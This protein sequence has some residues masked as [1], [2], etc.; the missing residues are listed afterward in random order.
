MYI[1]IVAHRKPA[2]IPIMVMLGK[3]S[4]KRF[5]LIYADFLCEY[6]VKFFPIKV[7]VYLYVS[8][9]QDSQRYQ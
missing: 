1:I 5:K 7:M 6:N 3:I 2:F 9:S 4:S 8:C